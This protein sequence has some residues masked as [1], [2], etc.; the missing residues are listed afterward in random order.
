MSSEKVMA[1][2]ASKKSDICKHPCSLSACKDRQ[3]NS[4]LPAW[5]PFIAG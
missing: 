1:L 2:K 5:S 3:L 4:N